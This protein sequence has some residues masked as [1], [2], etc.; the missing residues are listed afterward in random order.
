MVKHFHFGIQPKDVK[1]ETQ[2]DIVHQYSLQH[3]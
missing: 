3:Y 2:I 1:A